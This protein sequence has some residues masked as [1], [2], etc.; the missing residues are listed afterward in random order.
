MNENAIEHNKS[1]Q[2]APKVRFQFVLGPIA[3]VFAGLIR[4]RN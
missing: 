1:L 4:R 2:L 3:V